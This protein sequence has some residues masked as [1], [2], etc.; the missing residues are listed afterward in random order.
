MLMIHHRKLGRWMPPGGHVDVDEFPCD[1]A[2]RETLEETGVRASHVGSHRLS[3]DLDGLTAP[4]V[5]RHR[6]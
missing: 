6:A 2:V 3:L 4:R 1:A 5:R